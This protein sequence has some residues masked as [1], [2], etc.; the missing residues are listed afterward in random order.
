MNNE[1]QINFVKWRTFYLV[2]YRDY[3]NPFSTNYNS[4]SPL[5]KLIG[6]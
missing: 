1:I 4:E 2:N 6:F 3:I 5:I